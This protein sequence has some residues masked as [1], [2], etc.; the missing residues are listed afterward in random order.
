M[1]TSDPDT[2]NPGVARNH[3]KIIGE[4]QEILENARPCWGHFYN[5]IMEKICLKAPWY[6]SAPIWTYYFPICL[7]ERPKLLISMISGLWDGSLSPKTNIIYLWRPQDTSNNPRKSHPSFKSNLFQCQHFGNQQFWKCWKCGRRQIPT[8][9]LI[10]FKIV[11]KGSI[12]SRKHEME[13][14]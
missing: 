4:N 12:P 8:T 10:F 1:Q 11:D 7:W 5:K 6:Y 3:K 14:W 9:R 13:M 2:L